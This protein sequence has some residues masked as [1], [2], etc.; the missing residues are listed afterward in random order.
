MTFFES[1]H[2]IAETLKAAADILGDR[3]IM[4]GRELTKLH[5]EFLRGTA[6]EPR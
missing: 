3:P 5:Q 4:V 2:R 1:P 6:S